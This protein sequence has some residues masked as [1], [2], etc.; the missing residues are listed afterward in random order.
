MLST[1]SPD[2]VN[3]KLGVFEAI[4][5]ACKRF[6]PIFTTSNEIVINKYACGSEV[7]CFDS[8]ILSFLSK[9]VWLIEWLYARAS[10]PSQASN[11]YVPI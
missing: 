8:F 4:N 5:Y 2:F 1:V 7:T 6:I 10:I 9:D 3:V 11:M